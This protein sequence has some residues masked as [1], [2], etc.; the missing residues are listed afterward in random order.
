MTSIGDAPSMEEAI[1]LGRKKEYSVDIDFEGRRGT[2]VFRRPSLAE[3][4]EIGV[5]ESA[6]IGGNP[7]NSFDVPTL[8]I[9]R[10]IAT[11]QKVLVRGPK[12]FN[13]LKEDDYEFMEH[14]YEMYFQEVQP[15]RR[16][17]IPTE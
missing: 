4:V 12:W 11:F 13:A 3:R 2:F 8:N 15:F 16:I 5:L 10:M 1:T 6:Y 14:L 17:A 9:A 7:R